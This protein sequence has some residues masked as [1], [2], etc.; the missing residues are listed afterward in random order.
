MSLQIARN[1]TK[2]TNVV[3][4]HSEQIF[5]CA[6]NV[7]GGE[8]QSI[9]TKILAQF[10]VH[11]IFDKSIG[12]HACEITLGTSI[13]ELVDAV[14]DLELNFELEAKL[15]NGITASTYL[16]MVPAIHVSPKAISVDQIATQIITVS[17][18]DKILQKIT[19]NKCQCTID[20]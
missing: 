7:I 4:R 12:A 3:M 9:S 20:L 10:K 19:V 2:C 11:S 15:K 1:I 8:H 18:L 14:Q 5:T 13:S 6:L 16:K 17:G